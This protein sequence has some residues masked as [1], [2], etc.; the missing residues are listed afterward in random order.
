MFASNRYYRGQNLQDEERAMT[1]LVSDGE[2]IYALSH[3]SSTPLGLSKSTLGYREVRAEL[4]R[5]EARLVPS[6]L[7]FLA[8]DP[9]IA[10]TRIS[11]EEADSLGGEL[12]YTALEPFKFSEAILIDEKGD[13]YGEVEFKLTANTPG[14]VRMQSKVFSRIFGDFSPTKGDLVFS[15]TGELLGLMVDNRYCALINNLL[16][17]ESLSLGESFDRDEFKNIVSS[18]RYRYEQL[19]EELR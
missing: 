8:L 7:E 19:P 1:I 18:L 11:K 3:L 10:A 17:E 4:V 16:N 15:K 12:F 9:R 13:Y 5:G 2:S 14:Y 6:V